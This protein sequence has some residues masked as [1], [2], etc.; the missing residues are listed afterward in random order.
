MDAGKIARDDRVEGSHN[1]QLAA[2][3][4]GKIAK[5]KKLNFHF[6]SLRTLN[7]EN[8]SIISFFCLLYH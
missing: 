6:G 7:V 8:N 4:L 2:V 1:G 5:G 3:F